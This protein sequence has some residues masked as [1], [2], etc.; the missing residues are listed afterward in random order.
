M[1][2]WVCTCCDYLYDPGQG[3]PKHEVEPGT[4]FADLPEEWLCPECRAKKN[5]F[6]VYVEREMW[7]EAI[8]EF[9]GY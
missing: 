2:K 9:G 5:Q 7:D 3:D 1:K 4:E 8:P 6:K